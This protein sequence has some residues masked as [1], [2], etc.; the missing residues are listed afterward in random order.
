[1]SNNKTFKTKNGVNAVRYTGTKEVLAANNLDL[2]K[3]DAFSKALSVNATFTF[4]NPPPSGIASSF[5]LEV[6]GGG[7]QSFYDFANA[8]F[9]VNFDPL[10]QGISGQSRSIDFKPDGTRCYTTGFYDDK[11]H[12]FTLST[13]WDLNTVSSSPVNSS[14][15]LS[16]IRTTTQA[17]LTIRFRP[18]G[19]KFFIADNNSKEFQQYSLSTAW[20]ISSTI[21]FDTSISAASSQTPAGFVW[22][23]DGTQFITSEST[24][25]ASRVYS[26]AAGSPYTIGGASFESQIYT[27]NGYSEFATNADFTF[28]YQKT[29]GARTIKRW[30]IPTAGDFTSIDWA[31]AP[32]EITNSNIT[33]NATGLLFNDDGTK[34]YLSVHNAGVYQYDTSDSTSATIGWPSS[35]KWDNGITPTAP[36]ISKKDIFSFITVDSGSTYY[37]KKAVEDAS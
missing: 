32:T 5:L 15:A 3:S 34:M 21:T 29:S 33:S 31:T 23:D 13:P 7:V 36:D 10:G 16:T 2:S 1:M 24:L 30:P 4:S 19:T 27:G 28:L 6:T 37:G 22:N 25:G 11:V 8:T 26:S 20:D 12:E 9:E 35:I 17:P 14:A 18:D